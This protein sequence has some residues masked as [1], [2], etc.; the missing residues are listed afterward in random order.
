MNISECHDILNFLINKYQGEY[1][2][3]SELDSVIDRGQMAHY[4]DLKPRYAQNQE[5]KDSLSPFRSTY[6]FGFNDSL[7]GV[8]KVPSN[9]NYLDLLDL[10]IRYDI[11]AHSIE[12]K[13][14]VQMVNED[15]MSDRLYSQV[16]P[17]STSFPIGELTG[18]GTFQIYPKAQYNGTV[19]FLRRPAKPVFAYTTI[20]GRVIVYDSANSVQLE[21]K[22]SEVMTIMLKALSLIGININSQEIVQYAELKG[23]QDF[24]GQ[25]RM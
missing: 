5:T 18:V 6:A 16:D 14:P 2:S 24:S 15:E 21:W 7:N 9:L 13:V 22:E 20:S 23:N 10:S 4:A 8:V 19:T 17:V 3:P 25:N 12:R 1:F 11:S